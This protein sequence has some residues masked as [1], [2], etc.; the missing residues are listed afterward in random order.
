MLILF[1]QELVVAAKSLRIESILYQTKIDKDSKIL[2]SFN[3]FFKLRIRF[4]NELHEVPFFRLSSEI[5]FHLNINPL[6]E[7][8]LI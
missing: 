1:K 7:F 5:S 3:D 6:Q 2:K 4:W 8:H